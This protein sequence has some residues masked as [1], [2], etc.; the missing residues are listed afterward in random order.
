MA[1][2]VT[3][4]SC[5]TCD[6]KYVI[7][8]ILPNH[9]LMFVT[10]VEVVPHKFVHWDFGKTAKFFSS[11]GQA[12]DICFGLNVNGYPTFVMEVPDYFNESDF[13]NPSEP[14]KRTKKAVA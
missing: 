12:E 11:K 8:K 3:F 14:K 4:G 7:V 2:K 6:V 1:K 5:A 10:D 13:K 9:K